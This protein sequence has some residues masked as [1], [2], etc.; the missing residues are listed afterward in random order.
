MVL[1]KPWGREEQQETQ[2]LPVRSHH[3]EGSWEEAVSGERRAK[4]EAG[5]REGAE[6]RNCFWAAPTSS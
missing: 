4:S 3:R 2:G 6:R 5:Q 1:L